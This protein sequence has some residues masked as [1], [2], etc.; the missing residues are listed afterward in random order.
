M[1]SSVKPVL[2]EAIADWIIQHSEEI[3]KTY[4]IYL[5][6]SMRGLIIQMFNTFFESMAYQKKLIRKNEGE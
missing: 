2:C 5:D 1:I 4:D 3:E 6:E